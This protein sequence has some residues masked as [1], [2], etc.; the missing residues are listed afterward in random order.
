MHRYCVIHSY[1]YTCQETWRNEKEKMISHEM[2]RSIM[3]RHD[4]SLSQKGVFSGGLDACREVSKNNMADTRWSLIILW[5]AVT[6]FVESAGVKTVKSIVCSQGK[7]ELHCYF[8]F[9][10]IYGLASQVAHPTWA[11]GWQKF[12]H[13]PLILLFRFSSPAPPGDAPSSTP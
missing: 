5:M 6:L 1:D 10:K 4:Q 12:W 2:S 7:S 9:S 11:N 3:K 13:A 8:L